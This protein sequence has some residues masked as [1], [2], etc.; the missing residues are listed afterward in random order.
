MSRPISLSAR[1]VT[2]AVRM[3]KQRRRPRATLY[4][5]PPS[6]TWNCR[7]VRMR[8]SPGS[9]RSM[10]SP[11]ETSSKRHCSAESTLSGGV[12]SPGP[13]I[14]SPLGLPAP[15]GRWRPL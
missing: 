8:T 5:P 9:R 15:T 14:A 1:A 7:V 11:K 12:S 6:Q 13:V 3:P 4:S 2:T 10:I